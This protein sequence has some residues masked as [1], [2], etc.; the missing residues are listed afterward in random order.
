MEYV[1]LDRGIQ[2][3]V[4]QQRALA[5]VFFFLVGLHA[6]YSPKFYERVYECVAS[7]LI[8]V[9]CASILYFEYH[10]QLSGHPEFFYLSVNSTCI[11]LTIACYYYM[12]LPI[13]LAFGLSLLL[14]GMTFFAVH[15]SG[16]FDAKVAVRMLTYLGVSNIMGLG[17]R[18]IFDPRDR[19]IFAQN[20]KI[21]AL[22]LAEAASSEMKTKLIA[23]LSHEMR[24][25]MNSVARLLAAVQRDLAGDLSEKRLEMLSQVEQ[26]CERLVATLDDLLQFSGIN[27]K[28]QARSPSAFSLRELVIE[29]GTTV[30]EIAKHKGISLAV[31]VSNVPTVPLMGQPHNLRR[32][33][34]NLLEN[35]IKFTSVGGVSV[36]ATVDSQES[37]E[38]MRACIAV[39][40]TGIGI[41]AH[42]HKNIF[43]LFYQVDSSLARQFGGTGLGLAIC[44]QLMST[45]NGD[46]RVESEVGKGTTFFASFTANLAST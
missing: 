1:A 4:Q 24:T 20:H 46:I 27:G 32:V 12:R 18:V 23:M 3:L 43:Q 25:P 14:A 40:D 6:K 28:Q 19:E 5:I 45:M 26:T 17:I 44:R 39:K 22:M 42:E 8:L 10:T 2:S 29:C 35:A 15:E 30:E 34:L 9:Y 31:D 7:V 13:A 16:V 38:G 11:L 36:V 33:L 37:G 41:P 21:N